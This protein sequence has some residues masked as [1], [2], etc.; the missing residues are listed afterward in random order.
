[1]A[2]SLQVDKKSPWSKPLTIGIGLVVVAVLV[3]AIYAPGMFKLSG[4]SQTGGKIYNIGTGVGGYLQTIEPTYTV[5]YGDS[6]DPEQTTALI[7]FAGTYQISSQ[8]GTGA[9]Q[10]SEVS[11][12]DTNTIIFANS[13]DSNALINS[14]K[15]ASGVDGKDYAIAMV[16]DEQKGILTVIGGTK[17][18]TTY[19]INFLKNR[20]APDESVLCEKLNSLVVIIPDNGHCT[21][22]RSPRAKIFVTSIPSASIE[23]KTSTGGPTFAETGSEYTTL[24]TPT[25]Y[26][27]AKGDYKIVLTATGYERKEVNPV[28]V[29]LEDQLQEK[30]ISKSYTL[31]STVTTGSVEIEVAADAGAPTLT[32]ALITLEGQNIVKT[33]DS[34]TKKVRFDNLNAGAYTFTIRPTES[35]Y[36]QRSRSLTVIVGQTVV[37]RVLYLTGDV[38]C[39]PTY[40]NPQYGACIDKL[41][42]RTLTKIAGADGLVCPVGEP[43][44]TETQSCCLEAYTQ[45]SEA[46]WTP[47][48]S[49]TT[50]I[51][52][53]RPCNIVAGCEQS[54]NPI[55]QKSRQCP[56]PSEATAVFTTIPAEAMIN[57][58][59]INQPKQ[60]NLAAGTYNIKASMN[61]Y[62]DYTTTL[63]ISQSQLGTVVN[64]PQYVLVPHSDFVF[65]RIKSTRNVDRY[66]VVIGTEVSGH[67]ASL[68]DNIGGS[69][70]AG[71][72]GVSEAFTDVNVP[73]TSKNIILI[74]GPCVNNKVASFAASGAFPYTCANWPGGSGSNFVI[75]KQIKTA[76]SSVIIIAGTNAEDTRRGGRI[77]ARL[78]EFRNKLAKQEIRLCPVNQDTSSADYKDIN[79]IQDCADS[80]SQ[81]TTQV[82][83][84]TT[85]LSA[86]TQSQPYSQQIQTTALPSNGA[87]TFF[88]SSGALPS[89]LTMSS[90]GLISGTPT[91]SGTFTFTVNINV[92][93]I[94][95]ADPPYFYSISQTYTITIAPS[96]PSINTASLS[97]A[98]QGSSYSQQISVSGGT[99]PY[100]YSIL[101]GSLPSGVTVSS[102]GLISGTPT[103]SGT[104]TF[105]VKIVDSASQSTTKDFSL[106]VSA[107]AAPLSASA[108]SLSATAKKT[109]PVTFTPTV[110]GGTTPYT[111]S[112]TITDD[113]TATVEA[114]YSIEKPTHT[115]LSTDFYIV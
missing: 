42:S 9:K 85:S 47:Q 88:I 68:S 63:T 73:Q 59:G 35:Y 111:Y 26:K 15:T 92:Y 45:C 51:T 74:G 62:D 65:D 49:S 96:S 44:K 34:T 37:D 69:D 11:S 2:D 24:S 105:T 77:I 4:G 40:D 20:K 89:G 56:S 113:D 32:T 57:I 103:A 64:V 7:G 99:S 83:V 46:D 115:F 43:T 97:S 17:Q 48:C 107:P 58:N 33:T 39:Q 112:W 71:Y 16:T 104:F 67:K 55:P 106:T 80:G 60:L 108:I 29:S 36:P 101:S 78:S 12:S 82:S 54:T 8:S 18:A 91:A 102:S 61:G 93:N 81:T 110:S 10:L 41:K 94:T 114:T 27:V 84:V 30:T 79:K 98:T 6:F 87:E 3:L 75:I 53:T 25:E 86:P 1:M 100:T 109:V 95:Y 38:T 23:F 50:Q 14:L 21:D 76:D 5:A 52:Q 19:A 22:V 13:A 90:S 70:I 66:A 72:L 28:S 31:T